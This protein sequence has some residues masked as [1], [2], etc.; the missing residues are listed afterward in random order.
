[1]PEEATNASRMKEEPMIHWNAR[2]SNAP[3]AS[4]VSGGATA[5]AIDTS[6]RD[7]DKDG[8]SAHGNGATGHAHERT[9]RRQGSCRRREATKQSER[10]EIRK[11]TTEK[12]AESALARA[13]L[14]SPKIT[15]K[16]NEEHAATV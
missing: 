15:G 6:V 3:T 11:S 5:T 7:T 2:I 9:G 12:Q 10:P 8:V 14:I 13:K 1:M 16:A 4:S